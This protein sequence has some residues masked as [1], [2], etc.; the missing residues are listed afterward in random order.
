MSAPLV[1][2]PICG[3]RTTE[4]DVTRHLDYGCPPPPEPASGRAS[5]IAPIFARAKRQQSMISSA[6]APVTVALSE[7]GSEDDAAESSIS[8]SGDS[9][10]KPPPHKRAKLDNDGASPKSVRSRTLHSPDSISHTPVSIKKASVYTTPCEP[11]SAP[12]LALPPTP[13]PALRHRK[14]PRPLAER[15]R[16]TSLNDFV[17]QAEL[18]GSHGKASANCLVRTEDINTS[19]EGACQSMILWGPPGVGKT[20]LARIFSATTKSR[21]VELSATI[22][23]V[24]DC[25]KVFDEARNELRLTGRRTYLFLDEVH[26]FT[27]SQQDIFLPFLERGDIILIGATTENPSFKLNSALLSRCRVFQ[28][29]KLSDDDV[30]EILRRL[31]VSCAADYGIDAG[32]TGLVADDALRY[33]AELCTGDARWG[34]NLLETVLKSLSA[35]SSPVPQIPLS[36]VR[37]EIKRA[38]MLLYDRV[39]DAHYDAISALHKSVRGSAPDAALY[40]LARMLQGGEDPLYVARRLVRMASEDVG[41]ADESCF[42]FAVATYQAVERLGMPECDVALAHCVV[43]LAR[44][45]K[46][47]IIYRAYNAA[48]EAIASEPRFAAAE[49]PVHLRNAPTKLMKE[50]GY[51]KEYKYNP[52][53]KDGRVA[54]EY[55][56]KG[57]EHTCFLG[58]EHLGNNIDPDLQQAKL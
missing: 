36:R 32:A 13:T 55:F 53:Y 22:A 3:A 28:L 56:P 45:P 21:F 49:I 58:T 15:A 41:L 20:T 50:L 29:Q 10:G 37:D 24:A 9:T 17:G 1:I 11:A 44:A 35:S 42:P 16:P 8:S 40:Y 5:S 39:G 30:Y 46:S 43:K 7:S 27:R 57:L 12:K 19:A 31:S 26:R 48:K 14:D 51:G 23:S 25:K 54:Q 38:R 33:L 2:C 6:A 18:V 52:D 4:A 34:I 47:V